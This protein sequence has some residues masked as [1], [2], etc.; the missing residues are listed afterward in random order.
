MLKSI[1]NLQG[2]SVLE[3]KQQKEI[4]GGIVPISSNVCTNSTQGQLCGPPHC[5]GRCGRFNGEPYCWPF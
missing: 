5:P 4:N 2:A 1:L 3:K